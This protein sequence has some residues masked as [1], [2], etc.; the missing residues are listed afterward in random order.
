M[1]SALVTISRTPLILWWIYSNI[2]VNFVTFVNRFE[3]ISL[4]QFSNA[5]TC[6]LFQ[7][8]KSWYPSGG[9]W[10]IRTW[11]D[12]LSE[13]RGTN[14]DW[15]NIGIAYL[16]Y[17]TS[18]WLD[19]DAH[20]TA[21]FKDDLIAFFR[22]VPSVHFQHAHSLLCKRG[23]FSHSLWIVFHINYRPRPLFFCFFFCIYSWFKL[24]RYCVN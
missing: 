1:L 12:L 10:S 2:D 4:K 18:A 3:Q 24:L 7:K 5:L 22:I 20:W 21:R 15:R 8:N 11:P 19:A 17:E 23:Q 13:F 16:F 9:T 14:D 6:S